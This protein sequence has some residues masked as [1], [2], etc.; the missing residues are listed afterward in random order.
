MNIDADCTPKCTAGIR[1][2][3]LDRFELG[4]EP[5]RLLAQRHDPQH[6][7]SESFATLPWLWLDECKNSEAEIA[8]GLRNDIKDDI[9]GTG[10]YNGQDE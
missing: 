7:F 4:D 8:P 5:T 10:A 3:Q 9:K 1:K 2:S 6:M